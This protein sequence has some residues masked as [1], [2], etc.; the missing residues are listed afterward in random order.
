MASVITVSAA[1]GVQDR[2][3]LAPPTGP[4]DKQLKMFGSPTFAEAASALGT[5]VFAFAGTPA[6]FNVV[7][8]MRNPKDFAK[9]V[10]VC[11]S[12]VTVTYLV[13]GCVVYYFCGECECISRF[14]IPC[15]L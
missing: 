14:L 3:S 4:W 2:P 11:Q 6:F 12:F 1:V 8:E 15:N 9:T 5:I 13:I 7:A 10:I